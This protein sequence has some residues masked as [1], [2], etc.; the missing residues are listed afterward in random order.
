MHSIC[1]AFSGSVVFY[2]GEQSSLSL[3][4]AQTF[5]I[6]I[7]FEGNISQMLLLHMLTFDLLKV[8]IRKIS[9]CAGLHYSAIFG[10]TDK[11]SHYNKQSYMILFFLNFICTVFVLFPCPESLSGY[12]CAC[13]QESPSSNPL[14]YFTINYRTFLPVLFVWPHYLCSPP[15]H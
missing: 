9:S 10:E 13:L 2:L 12:Q 15:L 7:I 4:E 3:L 5:K 6:L 1:S 11:C 14:L 8:I